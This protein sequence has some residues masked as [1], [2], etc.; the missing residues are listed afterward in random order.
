LWEQ[1]KDSDAKDNYYQALCEQQR[2]EEMQGREANLNEG[3]HHRSDMDEY[4]SSSS[5]EDVPPTTV[6]RPTPVFGSLHVHSA[7]RL[8]NIKVICNFYNFIL[9]LLKSIV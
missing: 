4:T 5:D 2:L 1:N 6:H 9:K 3:S 7:Y 8:I